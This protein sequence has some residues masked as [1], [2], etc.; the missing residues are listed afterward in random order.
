MSTRLSLVQETFTEH[1]NYAKNS[2]LFGGNKGQ[3]IRF[4]NYIQSLLFG[5]DKEQISNSN[6]VT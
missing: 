6:T 2:V 1:L 5:R 3:M 4:L